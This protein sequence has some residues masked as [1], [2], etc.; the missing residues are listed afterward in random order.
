VLACDKLRALGEARLAL[1]LSVGG[2]G[3]GASGGAPPPPPTVLAELSR[4][5]LDGLNAELERAL[6][7]PASPAAG[8]AAGEAAVA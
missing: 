7:V 5:E 4:A 2:G 1:S 3:G 8:G 6:G